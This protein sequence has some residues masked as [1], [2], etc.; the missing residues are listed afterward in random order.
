[1]KYV[2]ESLRA[3]SQYDS[4][5]QDILLSLF[6]TFELLLERVL[7][8]HQPVLI[9]AAENKEEVKSQTQTVKPTN[10]ISERDFGKLDRL[11]REKPNASTLAL[12]AHILFTNNKTSRWLETKSSEER[13][14]LLVEARRNAP[15][16]RQK[17][18]Q[19]ISELEEERRKLQ[20]QKQKEKEESERKLIELKEKITSELTNYGLWVSSI[21]VDSNLRALKSET[22]KRKALKAQLRFRKKVLQQQHPD[23]S[24]FSFSS[25]ER[26]QFNSQLLCENLLRKQDTVMEL[27]L[28]LSPHSL[29]RI[30]STTSKKLM[31]RS[32]LTKGK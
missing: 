19:H 13:Q 28:A 24:I 26:G 4:S 14:Q 8:D 22:Q 16:H 10:T 15:K 5:V 25:K 29:T 32:M 1:M 20:I 7:A 27:L 2:W 17:Y 3:P 18:R 6:K 31:E 11:L 12:E 30:L 9:A 21:Q 23:N